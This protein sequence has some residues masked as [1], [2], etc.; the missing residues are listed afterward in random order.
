MS[1]CWSR[2][3]WRYKNLRKYSH[4]ALRPPP[5][6]LPAAAA[7]FVPMPLQLLFGVVLTYWPAKVF[8]LAQ[9]GD[10]QAWIYLALGTVYQVL[11]IAVLLRRFVRMVT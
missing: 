3:T 7:Y 11:V 1:P 6:D 10:P 8:W 4:P 2:Y 5:Q 9:A